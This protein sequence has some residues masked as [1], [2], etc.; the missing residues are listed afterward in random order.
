MAS[1]WTHLQ[2]HVFEVPVATKPQR[3][4]LLNLSSNELLHPAVAPLLARIEIPVP[5]LQCYPLFDGVLDD[6]AALHR[7]GRDQ[8]LVSAGS[9]AAIKLVVEAIASTHGR[10]LLQAPNYERW[11][12]HAPLHRVAVKPIWFG[13]DQPD[14]FTVDQFRAVL[15][16][17]PPS[18]VVVSNPNGPTGF[19]FDDAAISEL[20]R[21]CERASHVL[22]LDACYAPFSDFDPFRHLGRSE[23][24]LVVQSFSK[25]F[26][27][28]GAR[29]ASISGGPQTIAYLSRWHPQN[30]VSG[31]AIAL[32]R[33]VVAR[34]AAFEPIHREVATARAEFSTAVARRFGW[35]AL[36]SSANFV[37][38]RT[39]SSAQ[40]AWLTERLLERKIRARNT[41]L[42]EGLRACIRLTIVDCPTT[43]RVLDAFDTCLQQS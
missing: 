35:F 24:V 42:V 38:V 11:L 26:G 1:A 27:L 2:P 16:R 32:L 36:P 20:V 4:G 41:S 33:A 17:E 3:D 9:D 29:I 22:V 10:L 15:Q 8:V 25:G 13:A 40:A 39:A 30:A 31:S 37:N 23:H 43:D 18:V 28:A 14:A 5:A 7:I 12:A 34:R 21:T 19:C 6:L